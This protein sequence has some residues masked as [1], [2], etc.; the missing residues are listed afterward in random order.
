MLQRLE[1]RGGRT[2]AGGCG[3]H[4]LFGGR[5]RSGEEAATIFPALASSRG[6]PRELQFGVAVQDHGHAELGGTTITG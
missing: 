2:G 1:L 4:C 6:G 3:G 5:C